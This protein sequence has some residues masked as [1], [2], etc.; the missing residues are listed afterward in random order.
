MSSLLRVLAALAMVL[1]VLPVRAQHIKGKIIDAI[2]KEPV[3]AATIHCTSE[4]CT[5]G[6]AANL[7]GEFELIRKENCCQSFAISSIGYQPVIV[8]KEQLSALV[9]LQ[10][11]NSLMG[12]V[13]LSANRETIKRSLAPVAINVISSKMI[14]DAK[15]IT[16]DQVLNKVSGVYMVNLGNEQHSMSIRQPMTTKSLYLYLEDGIPIRTTGLFNHN[17]LL[18]V[19]MAAVKNIEVL[20]GPSSSLYGSEAIGGVVNFITM[21]PTAVPIAKLS[22]QGNDIGYKRVDM[23]SAYSKGKWGFA[24]DGYFAD[25]RN[26]FI[27]YTDFHKSTITARVDYRFSERTLLVNS[28]TWMDYYSDMTGGIDSARFADHSFRSAYNFTY[29]KVNSLRYRSTLTQ[30]W[31]ERSKT[32]VSLVY[33]DNSMG[34]NPAYSIKDDYRRLSNGSWIG[35]KERAHGEINEV[36][37]KSYALIMQHRQNFTWKNAALIGGL[38]ADISPS[39]YVAEYIHIKKDLVA[40]KYISYENSDSILNN[41][42]SDINN[43][44]AFV[45]FEFS[46]VEKLRFVA[47]LRYD[48]FRYDFDNSL[49]PSSFSGSP[50]TVNQFSRVSPKVGF[51]YNF[52]GRTGIYANY[53]QGFVPPQVTEMYRGVKVPVLNSSVFNNYEIGGWTELVTNILSADISLYHLDGINEII[54]VGMDDGSTENRNAGKTSHKGIEIGINVNPVKSVS[55]RFGGAFSEHRFTEFVE[56][57]TS[58]SG[59]EMNGAPQWMHNAEIWY[60]PSF[61][62]GLRLGLEWQKIGS[63]YLDPLNTTKYD[64]Y[65]VF[66]VRAGY[67]L[68]EMEIWVNLMNATDKYY[69]YTA[70][71]SNFGYSYTPAEPRNFNIGLSYDFADLLK[72]K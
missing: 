4:G 40:K 12:T 28:L 30:I 33:R 31:N 41:Y 67:R 71:K 54:S 25:K 8:Q 38:S 53:S 72:R 13:V 32:T 46:P 19:N 15:P 58:Y 61:I 3:V 29:R 36:S 20:K 64:G 69:A 49:T 1:T 44:A 22:L 9:T 21:A 5:C 52:S 70:S 10:P 2:T 55:L 17:A 43:Y 39:Q 42:T 47:S 50:D 14:Q 45:N 6:C 48:M 66:N 16:I 63:Y 26:S 51:T 68:R 7:N 35:N 23:Q 24:L 37:F 18:E 34:Q 11:A 27:E 60:R 65:D 56:K 57:G 59:K 62:A